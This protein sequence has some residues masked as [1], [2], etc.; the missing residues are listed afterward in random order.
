MAP[1]IGY[2]QVVTTTY[3]QTVTTHTFTRVDPGEYE[4]EKDENDVRC[5]QGNC[6]WADGSHYEGEWK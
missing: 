4:G 1:T 5:G 3:H 2:Q 6:K